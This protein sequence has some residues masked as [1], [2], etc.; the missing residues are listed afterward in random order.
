[1]PPDIEIPSRFT[2]W[3][4]FSLFH[5]SALWTLAHS[6]IFFVL[7]VSFKYLNYGG[8]YACGDSGPDFYEIMRGGLIILTLI[9]GI[10]LIS[11]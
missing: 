7:P 6:A 11:L 4:L 8:H 2:R 10:L 5:F 9:L 3:G 1:M